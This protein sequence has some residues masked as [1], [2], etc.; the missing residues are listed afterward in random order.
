MLRFDPSDPE[1]LALTLHKAVKESGLTLA[2]IASYP[3]SE[4][5]CPINLYQF[6]F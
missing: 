2:Q 4:K 5:T 1:E 6:C 3:L